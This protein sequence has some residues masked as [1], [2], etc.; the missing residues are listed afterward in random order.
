[1]DIIGEEEEEEQEGIEIVGEREANTIEVTDPTGG[2]FILFYISYSFGYIQILKPA[3][4]NFKVLL[5]S[6]V[7]LGI[8]NLMLFLISLKGECPM[9][10]LLEMSITGVM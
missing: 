9:V 2:S 1:M 7:G 6:L 3:L 5:R 4:I 8:N 10:M